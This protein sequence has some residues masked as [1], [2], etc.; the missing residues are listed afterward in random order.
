MAGKHCG[1]A[2]C[3]SPCVGGCGPCAVCARSICPPGLVVLSEEG[4]AAP[5]ATRGRGDGALTSF[6]LFEMMVLFEITTVAFRFWTNTPPPAPTNW[7]PTPP[8]GRR[9]GV[10][11]DGTLLLEMR[12][13]SMSTNATLT[14]TSVA[15][16]LLIAMPPP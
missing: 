3:R 15:P 14:R 10:L 9:D 4:T 7:P 12:Q 2:P 5:H 1:R 13:S 16:R 11:K 6:A 8:S